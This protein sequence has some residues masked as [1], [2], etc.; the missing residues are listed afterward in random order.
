MIFTK[1]EGLNMKIRSKLIKAKRYVL[2]AMVL[3]VGIVAMVSPLTP[4]AYAVDPK[5]A[6]CEGVKLTGGDCDLNSAGATNAKVNST[7]SLVVDIL[8]WVVGI[9]AVI[10]I[11]IGGF[12]YITSQGD[13]NNVNS[14][15]NTILYAV[16]GLV[17]VA[18]AQ[19]IVKFVLTKI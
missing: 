5:S 8:S 16:V 6:A 15:K 3:V 7:V 19:I 2:V 17:I 9:T 14:A 18:F 11:I 4:V 13:S 12:K 1:L 10:M